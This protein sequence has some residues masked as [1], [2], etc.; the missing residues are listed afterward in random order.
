MINILTFGLVFFFSS[1]RRHTRWNC[2]WSSDVC[3]SDLGQSRVVTNPNGAVVRY[4]I[5]G[6]NR[7]VMTET[8]VEGGP[9]LT[10]TAFDGN[11]NRVSETD[12]RGVTRLFGYDGLNRL[13]DVSIA[14]GSP[15]NGPY[16]RIAAYEYDLAGNKTSETNLAADTTAFVLHGLYRVKAKVL[17]EQDAGGQPYKETYAHDKVGNRLSM[18]DANGHGTSFA[19]DGLNRLLRTTNALDQVVRVEYDDP[20]G[21][22]VN[23][24][25]ETDVTRGLTTVY[26]HDELNREV[27]R[28]IQFVSPLDGSSTEYVTTTSYDDPGHRFTVTDPRGV[29]TLTRL[30]GMDR[31]I[32]TVV[33]VGGL[34]LSTQVAYDGLGN[35]KSLRDPNRNPPTLWEH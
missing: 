1:R 22:H 21:S 26:H 23:K 24:S 16:G 17:P 19:Y 13:R 25:L 6:L 5:D 2:D 31:V 28:R 7:V 10:R 14:A 35:R 12:R 30:D 29:R 33:D 27:E 20:E 11:G 3:S 18:T 34:A 9:F 15:G 8:E 32:E 4:Q